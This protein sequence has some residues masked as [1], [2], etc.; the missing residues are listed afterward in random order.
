MSTKKELDDLIAGCAKKKATL[1]QLLKETC[2]RIG[3][4]KRLR[5]IDIDL[6]NSRSA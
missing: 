4:A 1:L 2:M 3:E 6:E 5:W